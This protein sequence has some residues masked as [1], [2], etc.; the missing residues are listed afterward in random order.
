MS[1]DTNASQ[2]D[3]DKLNV[4]IV[5]AFTN[6]Y[7]EGRH[8]YE[9]HIEHKGVKPEESTCEYRNNELQN[10]IETARKYIPNAYII[11]CEGSQVRHDHNKHQADLTF[12]CN[13]SNV[14]KSMG[15]QLLVLT[16]L[17]C[18]E[19]QQL[20]KSNRVLTIGK[21]GGRYEL[22]SS[23]NFWKYDVTKHFVMPVPGHS[24]YNTFFFRWHISH[25][26]EVLQKMQQ[27]VA[28]LKQVPSVARD[29]EDAMIIVDVLNK[30]NWV[31]LDRPVGIKGKAA[32]SNE[33]CFY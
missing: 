31:T 19:L 1:V 12:Y 13:A 11:L 33:V 2:A 17:L 15:D 26:F 25:H 9:W 6:P 18:N 8:I 32:T 23:Y 28:V 5:T 27:V 7:K 21:F 16:G 30:D 29:V 3:S 20:I 22:L 10:T 4:V 14:D 24:I